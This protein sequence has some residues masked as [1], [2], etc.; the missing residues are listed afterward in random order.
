MDL[1]LQ[2]SPVVDQAIPGELFI[3]GAFFSFTLENAALAIPVGRYK[4]TMTWS[5]R[6]YEGQLWTPDP[7]GRLP[8]LCDVPGRTGVR[9]HAANEFH[10]LEGCV[11][12]GQSLSGIWLGRSRAALTQL[13]PVI[14]AA[15]WK[16]DPVWLEVQPAGTETKAA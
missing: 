5:K 11:A 13:L 6:A 9:I 10:Q 14:D 15:L 2:R 8:L 3:G 12:V 7:L 1:R 4:V 16:K